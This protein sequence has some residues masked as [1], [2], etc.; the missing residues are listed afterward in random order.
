MDCLQNHRKR[1]AELRAALRQQVAREI[2]INLR[3]DIRRELTAKLRM[4]KG[5]QLN[6]LLAGYFERGKQTLAMRLPGGPSA[7][8]H[9]WLLQLENMAVSSIVTPDPSS[10]VGTT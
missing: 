6:W 4:V 10:T 8:R 5:E 2:R 9:V 7:D 1:L 3:S